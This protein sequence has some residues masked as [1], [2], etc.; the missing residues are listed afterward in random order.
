V[1]II[2][3]KCTARYAIP[4]SAISEKGRLVKCAKCAHQWIVKLEVTRPLDEEVKLVQESQTSEVTVT[5]KESDK[6][7]TIVIIKTPMMLKLAPLMLVLLISLT[8]LTFYSK[9]LSRYIPHMSALYL[10]QD[11]YDT[12]NVAMQDI[13][14][15]KQQT[16]NGANITITGKITNLSTEPKLIPLLAITISDKYK[17]KIKTQVLSQNGAMLNPGESHVI[18]SRFTN[19]PDLIDYINL[20]IGNKL[21]LFFAK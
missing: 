3:E 15:S 9:E 21:E 11:I 20:D 17:D 1:I 12:S 4:D 10:K 19:V 14:F 5:K 6:T 8:L 16:D 7:P 18:N 13:A 2:C